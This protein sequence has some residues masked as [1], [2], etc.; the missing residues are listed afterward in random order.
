[1]KKVASGRVS[2]YPNQTYGKMWS[3]ARLTMTT[4]GQQGAG[5]N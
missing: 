5:G 2:I 4:I 1:M 3:E